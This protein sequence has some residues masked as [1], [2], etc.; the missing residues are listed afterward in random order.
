MAGEVVL[1]DRELH[2]YAIVPDVYV[3]YDLTERR[4]DFI[5]HRSN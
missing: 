3:V 4:N 1:L 2:L 5:F